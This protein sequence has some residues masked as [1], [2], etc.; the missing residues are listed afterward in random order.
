MPQSS[1]VLS[2]WLL[3]P[4]NIYCGQERTGNR[5]ESVDRQ[6]QGWHQ[7]S[8]IT[9]H[10][11]CD[12]CPWELQSQWSF[13]SSTCSLFLYSSAWP[14][15]LTYRGCSVVSM[16]G[17]GSVQDI[18]RGRLKRL[19]VKMTRW[20][21]ALPHLPHPPGSDVLAEGTNG[22]Q[23]CMCVF[24]GMYT[25]VLMYVACIP[26]WEAISS[27]SYLSLCDFPSRGWCQML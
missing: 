14:N 10:F 26:T 11:K 25:C 9:V 27:I 17:V 1:K 7:G 13:L 20:F 6:T 24:A 23:F 8:S 16:H 4:F 15:P 2:A 19:Q 3:R 22:H 12:F 5:M 21:P 18:C